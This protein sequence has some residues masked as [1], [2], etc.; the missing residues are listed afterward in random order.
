MKYVISIVMVL[1]IL[2]SLTACFSEDITMPYSSREYEDGDWTLES[3]VKH[4][5]GLGFTD[6]DT[7]DET[8]Y[9]GEFKDD[10][11]R[12]E[13]EAETDSWYTE[14]KDFEAGDVFSSSTKIRIFYRSTQEYLTVENCPELAEILLGSVNGDIY[15]AQ[16]FAKEYD[17]EWIKFEAY[18]YHTME[19]GVASVVTGDYLTD[20]TKGCHIIIGDSDDLFDS[21][22]NVQKGQCIIVCGQIDGYIS[23]YWDTIYV[24]AH[25]LEVIE[26]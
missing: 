2:F 10:V 19:D 21:D 4:L 23:D 26:D 18:V 5:E 24:E 16:E 8:V 15:A 12:V 3:L 9:F 11:Y 7:C 1:A 25:V 22:K 13:I 17:G 14:Y 20:K 6:I